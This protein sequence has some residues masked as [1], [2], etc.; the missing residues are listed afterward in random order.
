[1]VEEYFRHVQKVGTL[2]ESIISECLG[3]PVDFLKKYNDDRCRD[4]V[5]AW[6]YPPA[7]GNM[8][9]GRESHQDTSAITF[10]LQDEV[11][12]LEVE[13]DGVWIP[14]PPVKGA[15]VVNLGVII[16]VR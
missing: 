15:L 12:G 16:Q 8:K 13:K 11:E 4:A 6:H 14:I 10:V 9:S 1:M 2:I 7:S 5:L 3:L